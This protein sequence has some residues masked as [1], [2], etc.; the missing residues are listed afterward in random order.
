MIALRKIKAR[1]VWESSFSRGFNI[2]NLPAG[3]LAEFVP[4]SDEKDRFSVFLVPEESMASTVAAALAMLSGGGPQMTLFA[5]APADKLTA[6]NLKLELS[7]GNTLVPAVDTL[8]HNLQVPDQAS[9]I[10]AA[11][12]F[13]SNDPIIL[14][15][16]DVRREA[17]L[18]VSDGRYDIAAV[19]SNR[20]KE[21]PRKICESALML[22]GTKHMVISPPAK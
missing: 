1:K 13:A 9:L 8:H 14:E 10:T 18:M 22:I 21:I 7:M 20:S 5:S 11:E 2:K 4:A 12:I 6:A 19:A 16:E 15:T 17:L 3:M